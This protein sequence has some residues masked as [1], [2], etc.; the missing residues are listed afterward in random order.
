MENYI[1]NNYQEIKTKK[2]PKIIKL[3]IIL[4]T[5]I[6]AGLFVSQFVMRSKA[7]LDVATVVFTP[8]S[9]YLTAGEQFSQ[10]IRLNAGEKKISAV[11]LVI[12]YNA[13]FVEYVNGYTNAL[14]FNDPS[15][16]HINSSVPDIKI[17]KLP[18]AP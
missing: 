4:L 12:N 2:N 13:E 15:C 1:K 3:G 14:A 18:F 17:N 11:D 8:R 6:A 10:A 7:T 5:I 9:H 16:F